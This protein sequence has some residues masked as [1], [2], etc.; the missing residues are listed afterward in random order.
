MSNIYLTGLPV[1]FLRKAT[2]FPAAGGGFFIPRAT[3]EPPALLQQQVW[4]WV[5]QW[6]ERLRRRAQGWGW[7]DGGLDHDDTAAQGFIALLKYLRVVLLQDL[8]VLQPGKLSYFL[9]SILLYSNT[10]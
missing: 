8:A 7:Q 1:K 4:P 3:Y 2:G 9:I 6:D 10:N 5:E